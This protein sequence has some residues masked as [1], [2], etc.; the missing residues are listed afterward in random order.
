TCIEAAPERELGPDVLAR[1]GPRLPYL[2]K[3]IA[4]AAPLSLQAH[5]NAA[6]ALYGYA[7][8]NARGVPISAP[9]RNYRDPSHK[10][11]LVCALT[12]FDTLCGFRAVQETLQLLDL[13]TAGGAAPAGSPAAACATALEP[14]VGALRARPDGNGLRE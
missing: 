11:E 12:A 1:F 7:A 14:Y 5:P 4:P 8:E 10:P 6:Q 13:L 3:V 2:L 9:E